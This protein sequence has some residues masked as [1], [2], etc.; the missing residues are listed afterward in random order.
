MQRKLRKQGNSDPALMDS[1]ETILEQVQII[2]GL[3]SHFSEFAKMPGTVIEQLDINKII[4]KVVSL[5]EASYPDIE[6]VYDLQ[7]YLP[8]LKADKK[9]LKRLIVNLLDNSVRALQK[10]KNKTITIRTGFRTNR[11][12]IELLVIDNGPGIS[13]E[14]RE[15]LFLPYVSSEKKNMGLG[16]AIVHDIVSQTGGSI[17]LLP[18]LQGATFQVLIPV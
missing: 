3:V 1:T 14:V 6:F 16:L 17:K 4:K 5:Y 7:K 18:S 15:K 11:N 8:L 13:R 12:Q 9:K 2:K 10:E